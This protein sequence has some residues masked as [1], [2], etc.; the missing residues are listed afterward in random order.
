MSMEKITKKQQQAYNERILYLFRA[1][2][3]DLKEY[4]LKMSKKNGFTGPQTYLIFALYKSPGMNLQEL[5]EKLELSKSTVSGIVDR[6]VS[7]GVVTREIPENNRR[8]VKLSLSESYLKEFRPD[9][10][11]EVY[12][13]DILMP[14]PE[15]DLELVIKGLEKLHELINIDESKKVAFEEELAKLKEKM[16][17]VKNLSDK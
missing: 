7:Q 3:S 16:L 13:Q 17:C 15:E 10:L 12:L 4:M 1:L 2:Q 11:R 9:Q 14:A 8:I 6:L 5:S